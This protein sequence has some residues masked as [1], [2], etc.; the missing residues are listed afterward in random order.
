MTTTNNA[1]NTTL[2]GQTGTGSFVGSNS[3]TL[4]TPAL[5]TAASG[6]LNNCSLALTSSGVTAVYTDI[7]GS[8]TITGFSGTPTVTFRQLV[9]GKIV[10]LNFSITGT[11]NATSF[12]ITG[13]PTAAHNQTYVPIL[14][15][16]NGT[17][18]IGLFAM[19]ST[20]VTFY[21]G[22]L[23]NPTSWTA[24]GTKSAYGSVIYESA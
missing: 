14:V 24:S 20:T 2:S 23:F 18:D 21:Q 7:S 12:T 10:M 11:S 22:D 9:V 1:V 17:N 19:N 4:V 3:P 5:G 15:T 16:D 13:M 6:I 8:I